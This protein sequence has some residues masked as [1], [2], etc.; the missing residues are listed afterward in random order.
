MSKIKKI[1][2]VTDPNM[3]RSMRSL[4]EFCSECQKYTEPT[5]TPK[6]YHPYPLE[7]D[8]AVWYSCP[9]GTLVVAK[10]PR[11]TERVIEWLAEA[12]CP[13]DFTYRFKLIQIKVIDNIDVDVTRTIYVYNKKRYIF[14]AWEMEQDLDGLAIAGGKYAIHINNEIGC[15][16]DITPVNGDGVWAIHYDGF[17]DHDGEYILECPGW[18]TKII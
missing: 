16:L 4:N 15:V 3:M 1:N 13:P 6:T 18:F 8:G 14:T 12:D 2:W 11:K 9:C 7:Y 5:S 17:E 10:I